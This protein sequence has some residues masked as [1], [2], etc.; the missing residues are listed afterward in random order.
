ML[1]KEERASIE[2]DGRICLC[3]DFIFPISRDRILATHGGS[4]SLIS[5]D[6]IIICT[7]DSI[8]VPTYPINTTHDEKDDVD[9]AEYEYIDDILIFVDD[10]KKGVIDYDGE[11]ILEAKYSDITFNSYLQA[12]VMP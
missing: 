9:V 7:H 6:G 4:I 2:V 10:G 1:T 12:E 3:Y 5:F 11:V 8:Y